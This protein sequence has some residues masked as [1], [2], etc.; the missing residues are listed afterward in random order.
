MTGKQRGTLFL[1]VGPSG[2]G[3]DTLLAGARKEL[4][5]DARYYFPRR[6][7]TRPGDAGGEEHVS[8]SAGQFESLRAAG[9]FALAWEAH[10]LQY[11]IP[12][13]I[14]GALAQGIHVVANVSRAVVEEARRRF[15]PVTVV[16]ISAPAEV[17]ASRIAARGRECADAASKRL[18]RAGAL[19]LEGPDIVTLVND[20]SVAE[21]IEALLT[22]LG[23]RPPI[24]QP[25][26]AAAGGH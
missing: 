16:H 18:T 2:A 15:A 22:A 19:H 17:L 13:Q 11:G 6:L 12:A 1:V 7:I 9:G 14:E 21:G 3:K 20:R 26:R 4:A 5:R 25:A 10:A 24:D 8:V 23:L